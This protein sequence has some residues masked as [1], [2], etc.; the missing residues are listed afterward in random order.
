[1]AGDLGRSQGSERQRRGGA[2]P[3]EGCEGMEGAS[4]RGA[5]SSVLGRGEEGWGGRD[6]T[7]GGQRGKGKEWRIQ[8]RDRKGGRTRD[9]GRVGATRHQPQNATTLRPACESGS[10]SNLDAPWHLDSL[11]V[12]SCCCIRSVTRQDSALGTGSFVSEIDQPGDRSHCLKIQ[13][14]T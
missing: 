2:H 1:M 12:C 7:E 3:G 10:I 6:P 11:W 13:R 5:V 8:E 4:R 9:C 14:C